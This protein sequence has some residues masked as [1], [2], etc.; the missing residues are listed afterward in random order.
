MIGIYKIT[1]PNKR[2][3]IGKSINIKN[4]FYKYKILD[5]KTQRKLY[6]SFKK[7]GVENHLFEVIE[8]CS[9][10]S[11]IKRERY[12]QDH[13]NV[14]KEGLNCLLSTT[15][16]TKGKVSEETKLLLSKAMKGK[17]KGIKR[18]LEFK[19][20]NAE[21]MKGKKLSAETKLKMSLAR[22]NIIIS[23][24]TK[25]KMSIA[26]KG[27]KLS[28]EAK[29]NQSKRLKGKSIEYFKKKIILNDIEIFN[30]I[31]EASLLKGISRSAISNNLTGLSKSTKKG[32]WKYLN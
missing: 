9:I 20:K 21:R 32:V 23:E 10:E 26:K 1:S 7:Y 13:Y 18:S 6:N 14:L 16:N 29:I 2:I 19:Q 12:W 28:E 15:N 27:C 4:R 3:Y 24:H 25:K 31:T 30:S 8:E 22:Q 5:C 11:L 17:N